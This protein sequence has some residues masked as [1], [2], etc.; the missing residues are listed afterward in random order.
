MTT[1]AEARKSPTARL[2][3]QA[4]YKRAHARNDVRAKALHAEL[5]KLLGGRCETCDDD[6]QA[7]PLSIDHKDGVKWVIHNLNFYR[8]TIRYWKEYREGVP[9][10]VLCMVCNSKDGRARQM[11]AREVGADDVE[12]SSDAASDD[13]IVPF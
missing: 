12:G 5:V 6:G 13:S 10:R 4:Q 9:L 1:A 8:R 2:R 3:R 7:S 11:A